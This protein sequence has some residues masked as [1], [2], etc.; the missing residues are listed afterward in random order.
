M[1]I[2]L[3]EVVT[4]PGHSLIAQSQDATECK[5]ATN[6]D[7]F[8]PAWY[9]ARPEP[10][11]YRDIY[12]AWSD[13][14]L[15][16]VCRQEQSGLFLAHVRASTGSAISRNNCHPFVHENWSFMHNGQ[17]GGFE[18]FENRRIWPFPMR[19]T[20]A[21][22]APPTVRFCSCWLW[23]K[24]WSMI[25]QKPWPVRRAH[26]LSCPKKEG[27][28]RI[29]ACQQPFQMEKNCGRYGQVQTISRLLSITAGRQP[30]RDGRLSVNRWRRANWIGSNCPPVTSRSLTGT[31]S[32]SPRCRFFLVENI[33]G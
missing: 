31:G 32:T 29:C 20:P 23:P 2:F 3:E 25:R 14:N 9:D 26:F 6:G 18:H 7:G 27:Q 8:G 10:G 5:T 11:L 4:R 13:P 1:P 17:F 12:L 21:G 33:P 24:G 15:R 28:H 16:A 22:K 30:A 19:F